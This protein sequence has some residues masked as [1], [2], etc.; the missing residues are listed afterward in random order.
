MPKLKEGPAYQCSD[1]VLKLTTFPKELQSLDLSQEVEGGPVRK[2][3]L[4]FESNGKAGERIPALQEVILPPTLEELP[5][6]DIALPKVQEINIPASCKKIGVGS[7][8]QW[9]AL[10][11]VALPQGVN[12][13][14]ANCFRQC[15]KLTSVELPD[16]VKTIEKGAFSGCASLK[17]IRLTA[18]VCTIGQDAFSGCKMLQEITF[19]NGLEKIEKN[20]FKNC[21]ALGR[22]D[23]PASAEYDKTS[24]PDATAV[25]VDGKQVERAADELHIRFSSVA[26]YSEPVNPQQMEAGQPVIVH[27]MEHLFTVRLEVVAENGAHLG[28]LASTEVSKLP[29]FRTLSL[30]QAFAATLEQMSEGKWQVVFAEDTPFFN[31]PFPERTVKYGQKTQRVLPAREM[32]DRAV[33]SYT[34]KAPTMK[35][36]YE[37]EDAYV[38]RDEY[39]KAYSQEEAN[40]VFVSNENWKYASDFKPASEFYNSH[41]TDAII[42]Q[43]PCGAELDVCL[44]AVHLPVGNDSYGSS[45]TDL[46]PDEYAYP[47]PAFVFS[48]NGV[49]FAYIPAVCDYNNIMSSYCAIAA[50]WKWGKQPTLRPRAWLIGFSKPEY[51]GGPT[52]CEVVLSFEEGGTVPEN[53]LNMREALG[54]VRRDDEP[55]EIPAKQILQTFADTQRINLSLNRIDQ[56]SVIGLDREGCITWAPAALY[57][58][59]TEDY[60]MQYQKPA[61]DAW[62]TLDRLAAL[63][64]K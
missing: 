36:I 45:R 56:A 30:G 54:Y 18:G 6:W 9:S 17:S 14:P 61:Q 52:F 3:E 38:Q 43:I 28:F 47:I 63:A 2:V 5:L 1:G 7:F 11:A 59:E 10:K 19:P 25:F 32:T 50:L 22:V 37:N 49:R 34:V 39:A 53:K 31:T 33:L 44:D 55:W 35:P 4:G 46:E 62:I 48:W 41:I 8:A 27:A 24:F 16:T 20:A 12:K 15:K 58:A 60:L 21:K 29:R 42:E 23:L 26:L 51:Q 40:R 13:I 64:D 57:Q